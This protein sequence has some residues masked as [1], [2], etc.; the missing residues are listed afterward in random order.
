M[1]VTLT[2]EIAMAAGKDAANSSARAAGRSKWNHADYRKAVQVTAKLM[3]I[4]DRES[5]RKRLP[6]RTESAAA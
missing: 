3:A 4:L 5:G 1:N 6:I 2:Y